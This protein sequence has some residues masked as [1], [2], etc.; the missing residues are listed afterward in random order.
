ML[1]ELEAQKDVT[2]PLLTWITLHR[3]LAMLFEGREAEAARSLPR[4]KIAASIHMTPRRR[5]TSNFFIDVAHNLADQAPVITR[6]ARDLNKTNYEAIAFLLYGLK[7]WH[8]GKFEDGRFLL[9]QFKSSR[10][11]APTIGSAATCH[12]PRSIS[13]PTWTTTR[14]RRNCVRRIQSRK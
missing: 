1:A 3:G 5:R 8:K 2:Q 14:S 6:V 10:P 11:E 12:W 7:N 4:S 13:T 9:Q